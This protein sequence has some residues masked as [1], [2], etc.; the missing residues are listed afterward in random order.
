MKYNK[1][2]KTTFFILIAAI[3]LLSSCGSRKSITLFNAPTDFITD[4]IKQVF[5]VNDQG[6]RDLFYRIKVN[7][8]LAIRNIQDKY[9]GGSKVIA[10]PGAQSSG[11]ISYQVD[12]DSTVN[13][14]VLGKIKIVGYTRKEA[15]NKL[16]QLYNEKLVDPII[17]LTVVNVKVT[18]L[19]EFGRQGNFLLERDNTTL[20]D[21]IG[22]A[23]GISK[24][25]DPKTLKII[26][27]DRVN[28]EI[29]YVNLNDINSLA[30]SKDK[31][32]L[33]NND[34]IV[35]QPTKNAALTQKL[36]S[37]TGVLQP[38]LVIVNVGLLIFTLTK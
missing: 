2:L 26:R 32:V 25:A 12:S 8:L 20:I 24:D 10:N 27:G 23:G 1:T 15:I 4:T 19:G 38:I 28:P 7:D 21:I 18:L 9:F 37:L 11:G 17:D 33:Q 13:L 35:L 30:R 6:V 16:Q 36:Q 29:I 14:P 31:L 34:I 3:C 5:V 22:E